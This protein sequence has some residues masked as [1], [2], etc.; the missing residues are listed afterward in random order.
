MCKGWVRGW[1]PDMER[2]GDQ[3]ISRVKEHTQ[4][5]TAGIRGWVDNAMKPSALDIHRRQ[6]V[7]E[8]NGRENNL[9]YQ[10]GAG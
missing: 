6:E 9:I 7:K 10:L 1:I 4:K 3:R 5:N 2:R 8:M